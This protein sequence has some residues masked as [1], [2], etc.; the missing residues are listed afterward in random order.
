MS[1][2][3]PPHPVVGQRAR[4]G[5]DRRQA[6][7]VTRAPTTTART[8][9]ATPSP[10]VTALRHRHGL[11]TI[12]AI[13][14]D[15]VAV[16]AAPP[17]RRRCYRINVLGNDGD[18]IR[19]ARHTVRRFDATARSCSSASGQVHAEPELSRRR[20][21][22]LHVSD[23]RR[24]ASATVT[25]PSIRSTTTCRV[26][27][28]APTD[29][30]VA[31]SL[32][33]WATTATSIRTRSPSNPP[34]GRYG[35]GHDRRHSAQVHA[36]RQLPRR[37]Q[38]RYTV[39]D[40]HGA[41]ATATVTSHQFDQ[42]RSRRRGRQRHNGRRRCRHHQC[43]RQ[44]SDV[45]RTRSPSGPSVRPPTAQS[46]SSAVRSSNA[47]L[48]YTARQLYLHLDRRPRRR[49]TTSATAPVP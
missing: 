25:S 7:H 4:H 2:T 1:K 29:E 34:L 3:I 32:M 35:N 38:L 15:P 44:D 6:D 36:E 11:R 16:D 28:S 17:G 47:E 46:C 26:D 13:N 40:G 9:S 24:S 27:D 33:S 39:S 14:D 18:V 5:R 8:T 23:A 42:R 45:D 10:T 12:K 41:W 43:P 20:Q 22:R 19:H 49:G 21:L 31:S 48:N 30:D 37:R